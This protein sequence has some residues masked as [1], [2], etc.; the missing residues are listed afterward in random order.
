MPGRTLARPYRTVAE[1]L[2]T[3]RLRDPAKVALVDVERDRRMTFGELAAAVDGIAVQLAGMG[4]GKGSRVVLLADNG[5]EKIAVWL[6]IWRI[7]AVVCPLDLSFMRTAAATIL[8]TIGP[9]LVIADPRQGGI[10]IAAKVLRLTEWTPGAAVVEAG[11]GQLLIDT[12]RAPGAAGLPPSPA[13]TDV[14]CL[15]CTS[16]TAGLP[17]I[18]VYDHQAYWGNGLDSIDLLELNEHDRTLEYRSLGWY[19]AQ[20]LSLMPFLQTGLTLH[21]ARKFSSHHLPD[22]IDSYRITVCA[23]VPTVINILLSQPVA[24]AARRFASLR[25]ITSSSAPLSPAHWIR[26]EQTYGVR[27]LNLYGSSETGWI[28]GNRA[29]ATKVGTVGRAVGHVQLDIMSESGLPVAAGAAGQLVV[30]ADKLA[31][32]YLRKDGSLD[33]IRGQPFT[34]R[35]MAIM[36]ADGYVHILGRTDD[37]ITRGGAKIL[38]GEIEE[39]MLAH[40]DVLEAAVIGVPDP[41]YGQQPACFVVPRPVRQLDERGLLAH[42]AAHLPREKVPVRAIVIAALPRSERGKLL[43]GRLVEAYRRL[44]PKAS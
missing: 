28:C 5:I 22:W 25:A 18:V 39:V 16:G 24:D 21:L 37:L 14:A 29:G 8:Q 20:I 30:S 12:Q 35:D 10:E 42:C 6:G 40:P 19:S 2:E 44:H 33:P 36:G 23:G 34:V 38:P 15:S 31:L 43:R 13:V 26:F 1:L 41:I 3:Y 9:D 4:V 11:A 32:G 17:K 7:G 27:L